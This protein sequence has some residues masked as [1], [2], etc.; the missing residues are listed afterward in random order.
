MPYTKHK[1]PRNHL[2]S[3]TVTFKCSTADKI[4][5]I[6]LAS[7]KS[8]HDTV[9]LLANIALKYNYTK[10][11]RYIPCKPQA[12]DDFTPLS[13]KKEPTCQ[14]GLRISPNLNK[15]LTELMSSNFY[16]SKASA[17]RS[18]AETALIYDYDKNLFFHAP[19]HLSAP[20]LNHN[21]RSNEIILLDI[22]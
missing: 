10:D 13:I 9:L 5:K 22:I 15:K 3:M 11:Y 12:T 16:S 4:R 18:L 19:Q 20:S 21:P 6:A 2:I 17:L 14:I 8:N 7:N 1:Q